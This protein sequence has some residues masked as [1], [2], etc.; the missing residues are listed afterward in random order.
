MLAKII[1]FFKSLGSKNAARIGFALS[2]VVA[3][4][5]GTVT[6]DGSFAAYGDTVVS[7]DVALGG[8]DEEFGDADIEKTETDV[9]SSE[10]SAATEDGD[11]ADSTDAADKSEDKSEQ[12][13]LDRIGEGSYELNPIALTT[14]RV[15]VTETV[16]YGYKKVYSDKL[17]RGETETSAGK[18][19]EKE[20][21]YT[22]VMLN[23]VEV[24]RDSFSEE[25]T[26]EPVAQVETI[27]TKLHAS[28]AVMTSEDVECIST[29]K[30][31][32]PIEL[33]KNGVPVNY[34]KVI[35]GKSSAYC[36]KC[37]NN[38]TAIGLPAQPGL[39]AVNFSQIPKYTKMYIVA[40]D[41][42][43]YGYAIAADTGGFASNGSKRVVDVR[44]PTGSKCTCGSNWGVKNV[45]IY[46][47]E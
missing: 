3:L 36:G 37:D 27:G 46:I 11:N 13:K 14:T 17:Y 9:V 10:D 4:T 1:G 18:N 2:A 26:K 24:Y 25:I 8:A 43:V 28:A 39:V 40:N 35:T 47:L 29:L 7:V 22:V 32:S 42:T 12:A 31:D 21:I 20:V 23:G 38:M 6:A 5:V 15:T 33:D 30:P 44:M 45:K 34:T 19:G 41:G 16:K